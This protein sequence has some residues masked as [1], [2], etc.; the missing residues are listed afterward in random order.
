MLNVASS[1]RFI[2]TQG[3]LYTTP[4]DTTPF[5]KTEE[6]PCLMFAKENSSVID[7]RGKKAR[8]VPVRKSDRKHLRGRAE[9]YMK[10]CY[11]EDLDP[12]ISDLIGDI[13]GT[14]QLI[15][16]SMH[17]GNRNGN[18]TKTTLYIRHPDREDSESMWPYRQ[19]PQC[20]W[21]EIEEEANRLTR[22]VPTI[23]F[24]SVVVPHLDPEHLKRTVVSVPSEVSK[25]V[26]RGA[27]LMK[28]GMRTLPHR[29]PMD[30]MVHV[31]VQGNPQPFAVG[32]LGNDIQ[33]VD[34]VGI[35]RQGIGVHIVTS[36]GDD[37]WKQQVSSKEIKDDS[38]MGPFGAPYDANNYGNIGFEE[39]SHVYALMENVDKDPDS[40]PGGRENKGDEAGESVPLSSEDI[41]SA[42][43]NEEVLHLAVCKGLAGLNIKKDLPMPMSIFYGQHVLPNRP[44]GCTIDLKN[45]KYKKFGAY[46]RE[47]VEEGLLEVGPDGSK[48]DDSF[49]ML[50]GYFKQDP[51]VLKFKKESSSNEETI[52]D[53]KLLLVE[54]YRI[55][56]NV[57]NLLKLDPDVVKAAHATNPK[58]QNTGLLTMKEIQTILDDYTSREGLVNRG[59]I[60]LDGPLTDALFGKSSTNTP[61]VMKRQDAM[62][63]WIGIMG[64]GFALV[65]MPENDIIQIAN[66]K[67][68]EIKM[69]VYRRGGSKFVT[70]LRGLENFGIDSAEF[71]NEV[72]HRFACSSSIDEEA[73]KRERLPKGHVELEFQGNLSTELEA[74]LTNSPEMTSHGGAKDSPY[75]LPRNCI[76]ITLRKGVTSRKK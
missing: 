63:A 73:D 38:L 52:A 29:I 54:L 65:R 36:Y 20:I 3:T 37:I 19:S 60:Q 16:R 24:L 45:T 31:C 30:G 8:D 47:K 32:I 17:V 12:N 50:V 67:A 43:S 27:D 34:D 61:T 75:N 49:A 25:Y 33:S 72:S 26:C 5:S 22:Q 69:E 18:S 70:R 59:I 21:I 46:V 55:P 1:F 7:K 14:G 13:F 9:E 42:L 58:R 44:D 51:M 39:G 6:S 35:G 68:P 40:I 56:N 41:P 4:T 53:K 2:S 64:K 23:A 76:K 15:A 10:R 48:N 66:G 11:S 28:A 62:K 57:Q 74:L 71:A